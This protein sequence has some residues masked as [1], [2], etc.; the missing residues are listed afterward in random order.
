M[1]FESPARQLGVPLSELGASYAAPESAIPM[2]PA[3]E[4]QADEPVAPQAPPQ[5]AIQ[6]AAALQQAMG[7]PVGPGPVITPSGSIFT[8][9]WFLGGGAILIV[10]LILGGWFLY[11]RK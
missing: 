6:V 11:K 7:A 10:A 2:I 3:V 4:V 9:S 5:G 8:N 1:S